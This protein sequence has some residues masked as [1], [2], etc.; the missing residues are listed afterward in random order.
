MINGS[1][2]CREGFWPRA[3][4]YHRKTQPTSTWY[5]GGRFLRGTDILPS[6][7]FYPMMSFDC[8]S[9][10]HYPH[11]AHKGQLPRPRAEWRM[12]LEGQTESIRHT[13]IKW[14]NVLRTRNTHSSDDIAIVVVCLL[15]AYYMPGI[16]VFLYG[17]FYSLQK[18]YE[19]GTVIFISKV[20]KWDLQRWYH[21][22]K[23]TSTKAGIRTKSVGP[24]VSHSLSL[25]YHKVYV[26]FE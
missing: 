19:L 24:Q 7:S 2:E 4:G 22:A 26:R 9:T 15:R 11:I 13:G 12:D 21:L 25:L 5:R 20:K 6:F 14:E 10:G 17:I 16:R 1:E 8:L 18:S 3:E 23:V